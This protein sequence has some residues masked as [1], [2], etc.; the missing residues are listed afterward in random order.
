MEQVLF[1]IL[2]TFDVLVTLSLIF[3]MFRWPFFSYIKECILIALLCSIESFITRMVLHIP[4]WDM[5][6]QFTIIVLSLRFIIKVN[7]YHSL[8]LALVGTLAYSEFVIIV[9]MLLDS[10]GIVTSNV[11]MQSSGLGI[12]TFQFI[13]EC[14]GA[15]IS[16][17]IYKFNLGF[18][19]VAVP[20]HERIRKLTK[21]EKITLT[22]HSIAVLLLTS[23]MFWIINFGGVGYKVVLVGLL[24]LVAVLYLAYKE[25]YRL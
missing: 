19:Y 20:P 9:F 8:T 12:F 15:L 18:S 2:G 14:T 1:L 6:G 16:F 3:I 21:R 10:L 24:T 5:V 11:A 17:L 7:P 25:E 22:F 4:E 23:V 13:C